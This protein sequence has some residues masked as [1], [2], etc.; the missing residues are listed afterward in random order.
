MHVDIYWS[1]ICVRRCRGVIVISRGVRFFAERKKQ[2][3][4]DGYD[5]TQQSQQ[6]YDV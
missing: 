1:G 5:D 2:N 3:R 6:R 4:N